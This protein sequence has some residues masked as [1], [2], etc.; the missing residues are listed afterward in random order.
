MNFLLPLLFCATVILFFGSA[1][2]MK[3]LELRLGGWLLGA[4]ATGAVTGLAFTAGAD[5]VRP[6]LRT[7][8]IVA[9][10]SI[11]A[12]WLFRREHAPDPFEGLLRGGLLAAGFAIPAALDSGETFGTIAIALLASLAAGAVASWMSDA[13]SRIATLAFVLASS[14]IA[15][16]A[17]A[18][19]VEIADPVAMAFTVAIATAVGAAASPFLLFPGVAEELEQ[20]SELGIVPRAMVPRISHPLR[21]MAKGGLE[22]EAHRR[23]VQVAWRLALRRRRHRSMGFEESR[24]HQV[25]I[26]KLRKELS[27]LLRASREIE[28]AGEPQAARIQSTPKGTPTE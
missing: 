9:L 7:P 21:R 5:G 19:V 26:L 14:G 3:D 20:E 1:K 12:L 8:L 4:I 2:Y 11:G 22:P 16:A 28:E 23:V 17:A 18:S 6:D 13:T 24:L 10:V 27:D 25:E 15:A